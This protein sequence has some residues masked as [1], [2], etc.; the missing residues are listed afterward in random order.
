MALHLLQ[1]PQ[2]G[3]RVGTND[4][5]RQRLAAA[6][7]GHDVTDLTGDSAE[8]S[9]AALQEAVA[10]GVMERLVISGGDGLVHLAIQHIAETGI[11]MTIVPSG[12]GN[13]F[14]MGLQH[15]GNPV[16]ANHI[17]A[18][19]L[20]RVTTADS[21]SPRWVASIVIA[22]F[23]AAINARAN[24]LSLPLGPSLYT[25]AAIAELPTF[26]RSLISYEITGGDEP[27]S[28]T[29]DTAMLAIG[30]TRFFGG[31]MLACPDALA[32]DGLLHFTSIEG[33]GRLG[34]LRHIQQQKGGTAERD[35]VQRHVG[36]RIE[37][38]T[39]GIELWGDGERVG[40]SPATIEVVSHALMIDRS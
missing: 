30:N 37:L 25:I 40:Q 39:A 5:S 29:T 36:T 38:G 2:S 35:E 13:D 14:A 26:S 11:P 15:A 17:Q 1:N 6:I 27:I 31:G 33:V 21:P 28:R 19:D 4:V 24:S 22:G 8:A 18:V 23:P 20:L 9:A 12:T 10:S 32:D 34:V 16:P 7:E 3:R